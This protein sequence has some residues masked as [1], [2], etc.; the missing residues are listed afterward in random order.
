MSYLLIQYSLL[1]LKCFYADLS[2]TNV[3]VYL[4]KICKKILLALHKLVI[5]IAYLILNMLFELT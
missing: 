5:L 3:C 2:C 1:F 4:I